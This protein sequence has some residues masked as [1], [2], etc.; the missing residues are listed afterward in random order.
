[1]EATEIRK[2][3]ALEDTHWWYRERRI[4]LA[5]ALRRLAEAGQRPSRALDIGAA[6]GGNTR[7]LRAHGWRP[8]AL[9]Y[10]VEGAGVARER[11]LDVIRA[12]ARRLPLPT[13]SLGLVVAFDILEHVDEDH[14]AAAEIHRALRPGGT[15]LIAVPCDMRL[16]SAHDV[17]VGHVRRYD[18]ESLRTTVERAGLVVDELWSWNVLLR[19]VAAWRRR[20]S[21]GSDLDQLHPVVNLG[22]RTVIAAERYLPVRSAPGVSLMLRAHRPG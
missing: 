21:T 17:A 18:R 7:V 14:L 15:A 20:R 22:L 10:S 5:R 4:L 13:A 2:L 19:P 1:M 6:G 3:A 11:G 8:V 16:W 9:E 12:D